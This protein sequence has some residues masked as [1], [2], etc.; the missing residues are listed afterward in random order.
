[1]ELCEIMPNIDGRAHSHIGPTLGIELC[2]MDETTFEKN[3]QMG[4]RLAVERER[5][6]LKQAALAEKIGLSR[7]MWG[8]YERGLTPINDLAFEKFCA[9]GANREYLLFG[10][11]LA[12]ESLRP[13]TVAE[14]MAIIHTAIASLTSDES[15]LLDRYRQASQERKNLLLEIAR[16]KSAA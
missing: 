13:Q 10:A 11:P 14:A 15:E 16:A 4:R 7:E 5:M 2:M 8:R 6:G 9:L 3:Q 1:M 12:A